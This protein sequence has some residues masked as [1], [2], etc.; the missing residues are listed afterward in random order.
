M[1]RDARQTL[2]VGM[3]VS[4][5]MTLAQGPDAEISEWRTAEIT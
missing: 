4:A 5:V 3:G 2:G 1:N